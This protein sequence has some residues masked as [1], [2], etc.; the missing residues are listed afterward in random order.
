MV[1]ANKSSSVAAIQKGPMHLP[2]SFSARIVYYMV[3]H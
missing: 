3:I 1:G 2:N